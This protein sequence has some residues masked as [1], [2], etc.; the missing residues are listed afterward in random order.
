MVK[1]KTKECCRMQARFGLLTLPCYSH[2]FSCSVLRA[3]MEFGLR[4]VK[5]LSALFDS[6]GRKAFEYELTAASVHLPNPESIRSEVTGSR[7]AVSTG[8]L[9]YTGGVGKT[10]VVVKVFKTFRYLL[11]P[12]SFP[13][14][15]L[16]LCLTSVDVT[17]T[18]F[19]GKCGRR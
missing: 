4:G 1:N 6:M 3:T 12:R 10:F 13:C 16:H 7:K 9:R 17:D 18:T 2:S 15:F 19:K 14:V 8:L 11:T 5:P